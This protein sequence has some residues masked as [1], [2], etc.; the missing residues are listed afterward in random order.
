MEKGKNQRKIKG[1]RNLEGKRSDEGGVVILN[2][3]IS[4]DFVKEVLVSFD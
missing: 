4:V 1:I 2:K 3:A